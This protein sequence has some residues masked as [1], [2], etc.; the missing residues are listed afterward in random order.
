[1]SYSPH[2]SHELCVL[3]FSHQIA[4]TS[5]SCH[6]ENCFD[7]DPYRVS[8]DSA[9]FLGSHN[10]DVICESNW[11]KGRSKP[12]A[13]NDALKG[14]ISVLPNFKGGSG[15]SHSRNPQVLIFCY[16]FDFYQSIFTSKVRIMRAS[17][18]LYNNDA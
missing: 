2:E 8:R 9:C 15:N 3:S 18:G 6:A 4:N 10:D 12:R 14:V 11:E 1:M 7:G 17:M 16:L 5:K 13:R